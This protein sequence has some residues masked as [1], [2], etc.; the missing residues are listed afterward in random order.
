MS[1]HPVIAALADDRTRS[2]R[3]ADRACAVM[4]SMRFI[5]VQSIIVATWIGLNL[6]AVALRWDPYPF[7]LLNLVFSTQAA[8]AAPLILL[9]QRRADAKRDALADDH[10]R[11]EV[12][13]ATLIEQNTAL[14]RAIHDHVTGR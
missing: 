9:A 2:E 6:A 13:L 4:G 1:R 8:Y 14:T 3:A 12:S 11:Q 10:Y 5:V 7:I